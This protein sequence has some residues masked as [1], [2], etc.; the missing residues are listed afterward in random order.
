MVPLKPASTMLL[1]VPGTASAPFSMNLASSADVGATPPI[2]FPAVDQLVL[3]ERL[4]VAFHTFVFARADCATIIA[5]VTRSV[6]WSI[7]I[8][9]FIS[10]WLSWV[11]RIRVGFG[12][13]QVNWVAGRALPP[14]PAH[15]GSGPVTPGLHV[16]ELSPAHMLVHEENVSACGKR[17]AHVAGI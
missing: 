15:G 17:R 3:S 8:G 13:R 16:P 9:V 14:H 2:Q 12:E 4:L 7:L 11:L 6:A 5:A 10:G 1:V